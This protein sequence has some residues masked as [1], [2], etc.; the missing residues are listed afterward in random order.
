MEVG[1]GSTTMRLSI[2]SPPLLK[3][4]Y[5]PI[6]AAIRW[7]GLLQHERQILDALG[8]RT[9]PTLDAFPTW[10][11][12]RLNTERIYDGI[13]N[14]ELPW[15]V[16]GRTAHELPTIDRL[17]LTVRH[18]DLKTWMIRYYPEQRPAFLFAE[19]DVRS[20]Q[21]TLAAMDVLQLLLAERD[22][23]KSKVDARDH[24]LTELRLRSIGR[25]AEPQRIKNSHPSGDSMSVR[26]ET[27]Y[28]HII[29][30][31]LDVMLGHA[32]S[33]QPYSRFKT[34]ESIVGVMLAQHG[35]RLGI[36]E[37]TLHAKFAAA[38]R[39]LFDD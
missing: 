36:S 11:T 6:E 27:T 9:L 14:Q 23:L 22:S 15:A 7:S 12:L 10:P 26:A 37:R 8:S 24:E 3:V 19:S 13:L 1:E 31:L 18:I 39:Q 35:R 25:S 5:R 4:H 38:K 34:Q 16:D 29:G 28:L 21:R 2:E 20:D 33:G 30:A 17:D 32:P